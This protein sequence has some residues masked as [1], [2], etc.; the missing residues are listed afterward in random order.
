MNELPKPVPIPGTKKGEELAL[1]PREPDCGTRKDPGYDM[2]FARQ[3]G[4]RFFYRSDEVK[5]LPIKIEQ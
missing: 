4:H 2:G 5:L 1:T 3:S